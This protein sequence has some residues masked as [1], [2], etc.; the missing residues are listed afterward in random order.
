[1]RGKKNKENYRNE[2]ATVKK[3]NPF[4]TNSR[5][6]SNSSESSW[7]LKAPIPSGIFFYTLTTYCL[8]I[9]A[10]LGNILAQNYSET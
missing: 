7:D 3:K 6:I 5:D 1:M 2:N 4:G 8:K 10:I 9:R